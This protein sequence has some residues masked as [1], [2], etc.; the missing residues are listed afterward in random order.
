[1]NPGITSCCDVSMANANA[2]SEKLSNNCTCLPSSHLVPATE[3]QTWPVVLQ[4]AVPTPHASLRP[5]HLQHLLLLPLLLL[6]LQVCCWR[7]G[8]VTLPPS[9][10]FRY[11]H[12]HPHCHQQGYLRLCCST[13]VPAP[14]LA[15]AHPGGCCC[16][17]P[18]PSQPLLRLDQR[19]GQGQAPDALAAGVGCGRWRRPGAGWGQ[20]GRQLRGLT[21]HPGTCG[22]SSSSS[23]SKEGR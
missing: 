7:L 19:Q 5:H 14:G 20:P 15:A 21:R 3:T 18:S 6:L 9:S 10:P 4:A 2:R 8:A 12:H 13:A 22:N 11:H 1:M 23:S 17:Q 16:D